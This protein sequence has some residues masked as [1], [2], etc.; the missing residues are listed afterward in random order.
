MVGTTAQAGFTTG[1]IF[2]GGRDCYVNSRDNVSVT[3][4]EL[5]LTSRVVTTPFTCHSPLGDFRTN[6]T[7]GSVLSRGKFAQT[8][9]RFEFRAKFPM[10]TMAGVDS[11]LW[12]YPQD[13]AYG[14][15]PRSGEI[16]VAEWFGSRYGNQAVLPS[17]HYSG[18]NKDRSTGRDCVVPGADSKF[19]TYAVA[20]TRSTMYF[21]YDDQLCFQHAWSPAARLVA[22]QPFDKAFDLVMTQ[23]GGQHAPIGS[24]VTMDV[25][26]VRAW[27]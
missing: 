17:V 2:I 20:W 6:R 5:H 27:K 12:M 25:A 10:T 26:W 8:Y 4:G 9:G 19:H 7:A 24:S 14:S 23:T 21:Y 11:A 15:W 3:G 13:P 1:S 16:D 22:P 18:E